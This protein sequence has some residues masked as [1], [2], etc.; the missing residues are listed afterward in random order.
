MQDAEYELSLRSYQQQYEALRLQVQER[1]SDVHQSAAAAKR[2]EALQAQL[3]EQR[4]NY[5][6]QV[7]ELKE[8]L[9]QAQARNQHTGTAGFGG[10]STYGCLS[11]VKGAGVVLNAASGQIP[12]SVL[13]SK[14]AE[15]AKLQQELQRRTKQVRHAFGEWSPSCCTSI[16]SGHA[17]M[18]HTF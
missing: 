13:K 6:R 15:I 9:K 17:C 12:G 16:C 2:R 11:P 7:R 10:A 14:E 18:M 8:K 1:Q 5:T 4:A 3:D